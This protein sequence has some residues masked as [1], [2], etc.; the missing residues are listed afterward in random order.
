MQDWGSGDV[1][2]GCGREQYCNVS[3]RDGRRLNTR[4]CVCFSLR[5]DEVVMASES[6]WRGEDEKDGEK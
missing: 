3:A 4:L 2:A 6:E 1:M 5:G